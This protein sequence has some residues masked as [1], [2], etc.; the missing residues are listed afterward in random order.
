MTEQKVMEPLGFHYNE[1]DSDSREASRALIF[2]CLW[3]H[4]GVSC[5]ELRLKWSS[6]KMGLCLEDSACWYMGFSLCNTVSCYISGCRSGGLCWETMVFQGTPEPMWLYWSLYND[7]FS[8]STLKFMHIYQES[9]VV[10]LHPNS[11]AFLSLSQYY[12]L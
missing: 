2:Q 1:T 8:C 5:A 3:S 11:P 12:A 6:W 7:D 9:P 4:N 10:D